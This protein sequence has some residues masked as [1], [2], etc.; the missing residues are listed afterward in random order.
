MW[1]IDGDQRDQASMTAS[2]ACEIAKRPDQSFVPLASK[3]IN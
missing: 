3:A 1:V 2:C